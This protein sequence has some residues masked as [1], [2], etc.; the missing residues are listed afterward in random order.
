M[1][2]IFNQ[3]KRGKKLPE[4]KKCCGNKNSG[5]S[6][7]SQT[8]CCQNGQVKKL[9]LVC[10]YS[11]DGHSWI[12][13]QSKGASSKP[14]VAGR[15]HKS[16]GGECGVQYGRERGQRHIQRRCKEICGTP[17][18]DATGGYKL[19]SN[20]CAT[21]ASDSWNS[22]TGESLSPSNGFFHHPTALRASI[23]NANGG[24]NDNYIW[25]NKSW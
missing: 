1:N 8:E 14:I 18:I 20:N 10:V 11:N 19:T 4:G 6:Y 22:M 12:S 3:R 24:V 23:V 17:Q 16:R 15:W 13:M 21:F 9:W 25:C 7:D 5:V 2:C